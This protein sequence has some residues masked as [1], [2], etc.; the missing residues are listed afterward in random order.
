[1]RL[2]SVFPF[3]AWRPLID[4]KSLRADMVA[5]FCGAIIVLPQGVAFATLA[6]LPPEYGLYA[7]IVPVIVAALF[8]SSWHLVSGP[9]TTVS[10]LVFVTLSAIAVPE[11]PHYVQLA[12]TLAFMAGVF[13]LLLGAFRLGIAADFVSHTV[14]T[15]YV[16]G[17]AVWILSSQLGSALGIPLHRGGSLFELYA[18]LVPALPSL[19]PYVCAVTAVTLGTCFVVPRYWPKAPYMLIAML[20]GSVCAAL[21]NNVVGLDVTRIKMVGEFTGALPPLS[22]PDLSWKAIEPLLIGALM[23]TLLSC[24]QNIAVARAI[25][26]RTEQIINT[27]Q[28]FVG[29]G[30]ANMI[31][32]FFSSLPTNGS[33]NRS[34]VNIAA[35]ARTPLSSVF[36]TG[37]LIVI[38][39]LIT[40]LANHLPVAAMAAILL[41][42]AC[43]LVDLR[44]IR[45]VLRTNR[46][47]KLTF[48]VTLVATIIDLRFSLFLGVGLSLL[49]FVYKS[50]R[51]AMRDA[52]PHPSPGSMHF[53]DGPGTMPGLPTLKILRFNGALYFGGA[54]HV[55]NMMMKVDRLHPEHKHLLIVA[56]GLT[57]LDV[58]GAEV[59]AQEARRRRALGGGLYFYWLNDGARIVLRRSGFMQDIGE[60]NIYDMQPGV[61]EVIKLRILGTR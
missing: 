17:S 41:S 58:A 50:S 47:E 33:F 30:L 28:M 6:G 49:I 15:A 2:E 4:R 57:Y 39:M 45:V 40:S 29:Q 34:A 56:R 37:F 48:I 10:L 7:A 52:I 5:G 1:M 14:I 22:A 51:P 11:T 44:H 54:N 12:L 55:Q 38:L 13:Q 43:S 32:A 31:G 60:E 27:N 9:S 18:A 8:G 36:S 53:V 25:S 26:A 35:G 16:A 61:I 23:I 19:N 24:T 59:L 20:L 21:L 42:V 46:S 3:L